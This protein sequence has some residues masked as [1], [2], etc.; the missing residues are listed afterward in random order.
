MNESNAVPPTVA[1]AEEVL[2]AT[3]LRARR[4]L[5]IA[6]AIVAVVFISMVVGLVFL[7]INAYNAT[8]SGEG[9]DP[10]AV[11]VSL[12]RDA[13]IIMVAFETLLIGLLMIVLTIQMQALIALLRD[14]IRPMLEAMNDT[15]STVRGTTLFLSEN[16]VSPTIRAAGFMSGVRRVAQ[17]LINL[18]RPPR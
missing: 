14:E 8:L 16:L 7:S 4:N 13:A 2:S 3:E 10:G 17:E 18:V 9:P 15:V 5:I 11:V 12:L 6:A 1:P